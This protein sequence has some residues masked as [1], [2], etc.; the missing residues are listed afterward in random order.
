MGRRHE[1][2]NREMLQTLLLLQE[3]RKSA[4]KK[5]KSRIKSI[6]LFG[7]VARNEF[8]KNSDI[9][10]V[11][12]LDDTLGISEKQIEKIEDD[13]KRI[14]ENISDKLSIHTFTLTEFFDLAKEGNPLVYRIIKEGIPIFGKD[15]VLPWK[16]LLNL[17]KIYYTKEAIEKNFE[18][19]EKRLKRAETVKL[20][21]LVED[22]FGAIKDVTYAVL[23]A[24][25]L[26]IP[27]PKKLYDV[28]KEN[29]VENGL[30][31]EEYA[32][33]LKEMIQIKKDIEHKKMDKVEGEFI[34]YWLERANKYVQKMLYL[35][36]VFEL[37]QNELILERTYEVMI[38]AAATAL[39]ALYKLPPELNII[40]LEKTLG[41][42]IKEAF[43]KDFIDAKRVKEY[44]LDVWNKVEELKKN[45]DENKD[46]IYSLKYEE[47]E[48]LRWHVKKLIFDIDEALKNFS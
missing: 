9:D 2:L 5:F 12:I 21:I 11:V 19:A 13:L 38:K 32:N 28:V 16:K 22:C 46:A 25:R 7:S 31:E 20:L 4:L 10:V 33:W 15:L 34:D 36:K 40:E 14:A 45:L 6:I 24:M 27:P 1:K 48:Q 8:D 44:Y 3:F 29:L 37:K 39:K 35:T 47:I 42:S 41:M 30:L 26:D 43:K 17:G 18:E 23:M